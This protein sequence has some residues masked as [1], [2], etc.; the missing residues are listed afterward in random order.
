M[1]PFLLFYSK[2]IPNNETGLLAL[3]GQVVEQ[4]NN[5]RYFELLILDYGTCTAD[6]KNRIAIEKNAFNKRRELLS[7]RMSKD[8]EKKVIKTI[9]W[10]VA[11]YE[12]ETWI[13][14]MYERDRLEAF[15]M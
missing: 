9:V 8:L 4:M 15:E 10:S 11:L 13:M 1:V 7:K 14:I 5:F 3:D 12:S 2:I 6:I